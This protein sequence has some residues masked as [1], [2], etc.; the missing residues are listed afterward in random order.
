MRVRMNIKPLSVNDCW[1]GQRFKTGAYKS[2]ERELLFTLP[3]GKA[4]QPP[5][6]I[7]FEFGLSNVQSDYDNPVKP[8]QDILQKKYGFNDA[9]IQE[10]VIKKIKVEKGQEYF[11]FHI[12]SI[13]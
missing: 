3:P 12:D 2:Y 4:P 6:R 13:N 5:Y 10:A 9:H 11:V 1:Q 7:S 8:L